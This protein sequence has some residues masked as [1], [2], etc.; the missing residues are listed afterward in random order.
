MIAVDTYAPHSLARHLT[1]LLAHR[2]LLFNLARRDLKIRYKQTV[3]GVAWA[4]LQPFALMLVFSVIFSFFIKVKTPGI[5]YPVFSYVALVPWTFF[6]NGL[7]GGVMSVIAQ[8]NLVAKIYFPR[9][10]LPLA[11]LLSA[12]VDFLM[13]GLVFAIMLLYYRIPL[14]LEIAWLP[15]LVILQL[16]F[17]SG[18]LFVLSAANVFYR[19]V[20][21]VVPLVLQLWMYVTPVI[22]PLSVIPARY[23]LF[24]DL[25]P[26]T[27]IIDSYRRTILQG[28]PPDFGLLTITAV[29]SL[30]LLVA[31]YTFFKRVEMHFADIL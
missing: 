30:V 25:N 29:V 5:P 28:Q 23:R 22:Y 6:M 7:N 15:L 26:M 27:G 14:T 13:A 3:L 24:F 18:L 8:A 19:D 17:M 1:R 9:E 21:Y 11:S 16:M 12:G 31:A 10:V 4:V 20:R 2:E